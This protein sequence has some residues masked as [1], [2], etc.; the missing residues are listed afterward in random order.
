MLLPLRGPSFL[1]NAFFFTFGD[2]L[3]TFFGVEQTGYY[4]AVFALSNFVGALVLS[5]LFDT[6]GRVRMIAGTYILSGSL[7]GLA[8][9]FLGSVSAVSLTLFGVIIFFFASAG[10]SAAYLTA[11]EVF[12]MGNPGSVYRVLLRHRDGRRRNLRTAAVRQSD[13]ERLGER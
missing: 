2:S 7:L 8:G 12:P 1:Y 6:V 11:S 4:I 9:L 3:T 13:R 10:T 5:P